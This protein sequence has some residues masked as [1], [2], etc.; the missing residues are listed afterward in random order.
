M[1]VSQTCTFCNED[2]TADHIFIHCVF[3]QNIWTHFIEKLKWFFTMTPDVTSL[4]FAWSLPHANKVHTQIWSIIPVIIIW[5]IWKEI[6]SRVFDGKQIT[7][8]S[9]ICKAQYEMYTWC[10]MFKD[11]QNCSFSDVIQNWHSAS[12]N[13]P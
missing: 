8:A 6:N 3:A 2:E 13:P 7:E 9:I 10:L 11:F 4:L 1:D 5:S 12:F